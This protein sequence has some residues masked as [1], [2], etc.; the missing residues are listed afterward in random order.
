MPGSPPGNQG[1]HARPSHVANMQ[2]NQS[3][4][5]AYK[6]GHSAL[7][8]SGH[9]A[10]AAQSR[11]GFGAGGYGGQTGGGRIQGGSAYGGSYKPNQTHL[12]KSGPT[13]MSP[14]TVAKPGGQRPGQV[15]NGGKKTETPSRIAQAPNTKPGQT[16]IPMGGKK[17]ETPSRTTQSGGA[18]PK[19]PAGVG[20][21]TETLPGTGKL[22][23]NPGSISV[24]PA[25]P[26]ANLNGGKALRFGGAVAAGAVGAVGAKNLLHGN[27][28][29]ATL[30]G[31]RCNPVQHTH[32]CT[33]Y[34]VPVHLHNSCFFHADFCWS[35]TCWLPRYSCCGYWHPYARSWY[36][37][38]Q[39]CGCYLPYDSIASY[40]PAP[41]I[42]VNNPVIGGEAYGHASAGSTEAAQAAS[43]GG[44]SGNA[45]TGDGETGNGETG[46]GETGNGNTGGS[47]TTGGEGNTEAENVPPVEPPSLPPGASRTLPR[48]VN[49]NIP[50]PRQR[51][52]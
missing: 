24:K 36:Y 41:I 2:R 10:Q 12:P 14:G 11:P 15:Q 33:T 37:W 22:N 23:R 9:A 29:V 3:T 28:S 7:P 47:E 35:Q 51:N 6:G 19:P 21:K 18:K 49:P 5:P 16:Q 20:K 39:P 43:G 26:G 45:G 32:L 50:A 30:P 27:T 40:Q 17:T 46:N 4:L 8:Y 44:A 42:V 13:G 48:G 38:Y 31:F 34:R 25:G 52:G 1:G